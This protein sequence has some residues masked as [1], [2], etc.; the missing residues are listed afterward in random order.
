MI[1]PTEMHGEVEKPV[2]RVAAG[3]RG[4]A[5]RGCLLVDAMKGASSEVKY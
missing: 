4:Q 1:N 2:A 3:E 5:E